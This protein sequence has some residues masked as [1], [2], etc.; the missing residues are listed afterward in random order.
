[1]NKEKQFSM[2][3]VENKSRELMT[4]V[5]ALTEQRYHAAERRNSPVG[6]VMQEAVLTV[7]AS[8]NTFLFIAR[9]NGLP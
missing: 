3:D 6:R 2:Q 5:Y 8:I 9:I 4:M 1:M 7:Q